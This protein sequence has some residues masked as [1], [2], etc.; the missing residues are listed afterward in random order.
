MKVIK[1]IILAVILFLILLTIN[2]EPWS[3]V[4]WA[5]IANTVHNL[6]TSGSGTIIATEETQV[7]VFC[8]T[9]HN[10]NPAVPLWNHEMSGASYTLYNSEYLQRAGYEAV[11]DVGSRSKLCLSCHDGTVAIGSVYNLGGGPATITLVGGVTTLPDTST[12]YIDTDL[13]DDHPVAIKYDTGITI[14]FFHGTKSMELTTP[15]PPVDPNYQGVRL[16]PPNPGYVE[17]TSCHD[18]HVETEKFLV[19]WNAAGLATT[20][21]DICATCHTKDNWT[22][23]IHQT[24]I[25]A[26]DNPGS[27]TQPIPGSTV[28]EA[29]CMACHKTH[30]GSG[31]PYLNRKVEENTCFYGTSTSCHGPAGAKNIETV[32]TR[33]YKHPTIAISGEHTNLD[34]LS[35]S[36]LN[37]TSNRHGECLDCHNPHQAQQ[38][39]H[40]PAN[41]W[42]PTTVGATT[43]EVSNVLRGVTGVMPE[44]NPVWG[45]TTTYH[46]ISESSY[47]YEICF[48]CHSYYG[49]QDLDGITSYTTASGAIVTDQAMEFSKGNLSA[50]PVKADLSNQ[51]G[52]YFPQALD[53]T[54]MSSPWTNVGNQTMY[55]SDCHGA[56]NE[57]S[58]DPK[59]PHGSNYKYMLKGSGKYWPTK[60]D[61]TTLWRLGDLGGA[62]AGADLFCTNCHQN[63]RNRNNVH[64]EPGDSGGSGPSHLQAECV[65][66][67][68]AV[69]H[70]SKRSRLIG[71]NTD[72]A[73][74]NYN[75]TIRITAFQKAAN[76]SY[77]ASN[78]NVTCGTPGGSNDHDLLSGDD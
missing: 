61:G 6:S 27:E 22:G 9:P 10:S 52:S 16:Y 30:G 11:V 13:T 24:S 59:G 50:H 38:G 34:V 28:A 44:D 60:S 45:V 54:Q 65:A 7:C 19:I 35:P 29:A 31:V 46:T 18:P 51:T 77:Q 40:T 68:V 63:S 66:C 73:P 4:S 21:S 78:C 23:S 33:T 3:N 8:H 12:A 53:S 36:Y 71:Y 43:N 48:K 72:P 2:Y 5:G 75:N 62:E 69:P 64:S 15:A 32:I 26:I 42:Y 58:G 55:C 70:G 20:I 17:C 47:E 1:K 56:D 14:N 49:L 41:Q 57:A 39:T 67:H 76:Q 37:W 25:R 74:Y